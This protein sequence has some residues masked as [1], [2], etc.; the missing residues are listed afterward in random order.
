M[1]G[2]K[3]QVN[4]VAYVGQGSEVLS[5]GEMIIEATTS[6][7]AENQVKATFGYPANRVIIQGTFDL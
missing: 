7:M 1:A 3:Y 2:K 6:M 4:Y 5:Q